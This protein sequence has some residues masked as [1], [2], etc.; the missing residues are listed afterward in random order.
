[1]DCPERIRSVPPAQIYHAGLKDC[2]THFWPN[3]NLSDDLTPPKYLNSADT[4]RAQ[5]GYSS[6][7]GKQSSMDRLRSHHHDL[8]I[9]TFT[10]YTCSVAQLMQESGFQK[11]MVRVEQIGQFTSE[12]RL[13]KEVIEA[14][15]SP[16]DRRQ[17]LL[18]Q[19]DAIMHAEHLLLLREIMFE[20]EQA[21]RNAAAADTSVT[22][23]QKEQAIV[24]H[25]QRF[26]AATDSLGEGTV[27]WQFSCLSE[28]KQ[29]VVDRL[30]G[31]AKDFTLLREA[32]NVASA[33]ALLTMEDTVDET[34]ALP[35]LHQIVRSQFTWCLH[36]MRYPHRNSSKTWGYMQRLVDAIVPMPGEPPLGRVGMPRVVTEIKR[37]LQNALR[38][39]T[40]TGQEGGHWLEELAC[41]QGAL[42]NSS[43]LTSAILEQINS[44]V[45]IPLTH[46][47]WDLEKSSALAGLLSDEVRTNGVELWLRLFLPPDEALGEAAAEVLNVHRVALGVESCKLEIGRAHV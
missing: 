23:I 13:R 3:I 10:S 26:H 24:L 46:L 28:W 45:R 11:D 5:A 43:N 35:T 47:L 30:E 17:M 16:K 31:S 22:R 15:W 29:V 20:C 41:N 6:A 2:L 21:Y 32:R 25:L 7:A 39:L 1:M 33:A 4:E 18:I 14:F 37:R 27:P 42:V 12:R 40:A 19:C 34:S 44:V 8:L 36:R 38:Y 9:L